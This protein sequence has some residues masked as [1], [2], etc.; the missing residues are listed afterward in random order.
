MNSAF[1]IG[2]LLERDDARGKLL[3]MKNFKNAV[4][5]S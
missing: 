2:R 5:A 4:R 3:G 1:A